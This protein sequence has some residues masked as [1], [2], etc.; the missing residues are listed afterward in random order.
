MQLSG[1]ATKGVKIAAGESKTIEVDLYSDA[2]TSGPWSVAAL[3]DKMLSVGGAPDLMLSLDHTTGQN[4]AKIH[5]TIKV[6]RANAN[7][8]AFRLMSTL[9]AVTHLWAGLVTQ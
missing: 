9:G 5:L 8:S 4:G 3:D 7:G 1:V 6:L 2:P